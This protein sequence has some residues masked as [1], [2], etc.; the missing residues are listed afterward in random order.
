MTSNKPPQ[1]HELDVNAELAVEKVVE[2]ADAIS[3]KAEIDENFRKE[4][5]TLFAEINH[6]LSSQ[7][8]AIA[9][10]TALTMQHSAETKSLREFM[11]D[12]ANAAKFFCRLANAW[13]FMLR[14]IIFPTAVPLIAIYALMYYSV[15]GVF[16]DWLLTIFRLF[17]WWK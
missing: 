17:G 16:P 4:V 5:L 12:G 2:V 8:I 15:H 13:R 14:W 7:D 11:V 1:N 3:A 10:N 9:Q 6:R